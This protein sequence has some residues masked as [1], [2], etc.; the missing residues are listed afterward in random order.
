[1]ATALQT[2]ASNNK[3][4]DAKTAKH[5]E[6]I[7]RWTRGA[8]II[9]V[10]YTVVTSGVLISSIRSIQETRRGTHYASKAANAAVEQVDIS[11]QNFRTDLRPYLFIEDVKGQIAHVIVGQRLHWDIQFINYGKSP[12]VKQIQ[13]IYMWIGRTAKAHIESFF[14]D[15]PEVLPVG[16]YPSFIIFPN[17]TANKDEPGYRFSTL[18]SE[19]VITEDDISFI[20]STDGG[21]IIVGR[22]WYSDIFGDTHSTDICRYWLIA[23]DMSECP[24]HNDIR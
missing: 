11:R 12:A 13:S 2:Y 21:I 9:A 10:I 24:S 3:T 23:G 22:A 17:A 20:R 6:K 1:M 4:S 18:I 16:R 14:V 8:T 7:R 19:T 5:N 15:L